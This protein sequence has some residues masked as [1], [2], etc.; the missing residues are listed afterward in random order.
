MPVQR[1]DAPKN[2]AAVP[3][4]ARSDVGKLL[5]ADDALAQGFP[6]QPLHDKAGTQAVFRAAAT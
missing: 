4:E 2:L 5:G 6:F 3:R 1:M